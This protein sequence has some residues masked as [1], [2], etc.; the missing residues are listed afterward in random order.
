VI[1]GSAAE[2][3]A[4]ATL[5]SRLP[6]LFRRVFADPLEPR[7]VVVVPGL[8]MDAEVLAKVVG[9]LHY[10]ERQ[11]AML[12][13]LRLPNTRVVFVS[14]S[15]IDASIIDYHLGLLGDV[16][17][18][19]ARR[20]LVLLSTGD[21]SPRTLTQK[22]LERPRLLARIRRAMGDP[23]RA[24]LSVFNAT[25]CERT[26][27]VRLGIPLY[28]CDPE[29]LDLGGKSGSRH[30]FRAAGVDL[31]DG[32]EDLRDVPD[33]V[34]ALAA[35]RRRDPR[36]ARA[37]VKLNQGF[38]GEGNAVFSFTG[39][40]AEDVERWIAAHLPLNLAIE[41]RGLAWERYVE[42]LAESGGI[43]EA[44]LA[45]EGVRSPSVQ[46]RVTPADQLELISTHDQI[47]GGP[48]G[49]IFQACTFPADPAYAT[50]IQRLALRT[51]EVLRQRGVLGRFGV[52]FVSRPR[53]GGWE[54]FAIEINL[55]KGGTTHTLQLLQLLAGGRYD[56]ERARYVTATGRIRGY[57]AT[58]NV[59]S[60]AYRR[61]TP[62][63]LF[64]IATRRGLGYDRASEAGAAFTLVGALPEFGKL[65]MVS[66]DVDCERARRRFR[67]S[68]AV[69]DAEAELG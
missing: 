23:A 8:T 26:L 27:A 12:M 45:G 62:E 41:A 43:A 65:G 6:E 66:I 69:L 48:S 37:V 29:L 60:S 52:D 7:T 59:V 5:Q 14:S 47:L 32:V 3:A 11:L 55:R 33:L 30:V 31:P 44:W 19:D 56:A 17:A 25:P 63:D 28:G 22:I 24:H 34:A 53:A 64:E 39:C 16:P 36:L 1:A 49:Q 4:F 18:A 42:K 9:G 61:L 40:P 68:V 46:L 2:L 54:H 67:D 51:G 15:P 38:S 35:L 58:D 20:R 10:E 21:A 50:E 13:L 57:F